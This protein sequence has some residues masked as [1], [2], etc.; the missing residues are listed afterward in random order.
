MAAADQQQ[1]Q[2]YFTHLYLYFKPSFFLHCA[3]IQ[4]FKNHSERF[5]YKYDIYIF[6][7][8]KSNFIHLPFFKYMLFQNEKFIKKNRCH[9]PHYNSDWLLCP[10]GS[11]FANLI[12]SE[13]KSFYFFTN[14]VSSSIPKECTFLAKTEDLFCCWPTDQSSWVADGL[15]S[16]EVAGVGREG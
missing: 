13:K 12:A 3:F 2:E 7:T 9:I 1:P 4:A 10:S 16:T 11:S 8:T 6:F 15:R 5:P 14:F